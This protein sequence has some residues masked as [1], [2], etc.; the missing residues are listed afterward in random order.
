MPIDPIKFTLETDAGRVDLGDEFVIV[1]KARLIAIRTNTAFVFRDDYAFRIKVVFPEGFVQTGGNYSDYTG[2]VLSSS[3]P[4]KTYTIKGKFTMEAKAGQFQLLRGGANTSQQDK[5]VLA[6]SLAFKLDPRIPER[7]KP[8]NRVATTMMETIGYIPYM[9]QEELR[10]GPTD[11]LELVFVSNAYNRQTFLYR[12]DS[13]NVQ[14]DDSATVLRSGNR[15]FVVQTDKY[16][17]HLFNAVGNGSTDDTKA[18][19]RLLRY[20]GL[21]KKIA[22]ILPGSYLISSP[23]FI[24]DSILNNQ[25]GLTIVGEGSYRDVQ[26]IYSG[27]GYC[28]NV[29]GEGNEGASPITRFTIE[30]IFINGNNNTVSE[31]GFN[32]KRCYLA[33][34][35]NCGSVNWAKPSAHALSVR[36]AFNFRIEGGNYSNGYP[37]AAGSSVVVIGSELPDA[38]NS[39]NIQLVNTAVQRGADYGVEIVHDGNIFDNLYIEN[40]T[41][42][43]NKGGSFF[44]HSANVNNITFQNNH[45]ESAGKNGTSVPEDAAHIDV[46][47]SSVVK[48]DNNEFKDAKTHIKLHRVNAFEIRPQKIYETGSY[49]IA[50][51]AGISITGTATAYSSGSVSFQNIFSNQI[52][53][54]ISVDQYSRVDFPSEA[55]TESQWTAKYSSNASTYKNAIV[56]RSEVKAGNVDQAFQS[57]WVSDGNNWYRLQLNER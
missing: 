1:V 33:K 49:N 53:T 22:T 10:T 54:P 3:N 4:V 45:F 2:D 12:H 56:T 43:G 7:M 41:F 50:S 26:F 18:I 52:D 13:A 37:D 44:C 51:S 46:D 9:T 15:R 30:N 57:K 23:I 32:F 19:K 16:T 48:I 28:L 35:L 17:P 39:S 20:C 40:V 55:V 6:G 25:N 24:T 21:N 5:F 14:E 11:S 8:E 34:L 31:G 47:L 27:P 29:I 42:G 38:W 36:N